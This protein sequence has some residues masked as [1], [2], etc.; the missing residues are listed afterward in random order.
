MAITA[1]RFP[2]RAR[3]TGIMALTAAVAIAGWIACLPSTPT[4]GAT[5]SPPCSL[6]ASTSGS[7]RNPGTASAPYL[8]V[9]HL[10]EKLN[11]GQAGC[12]AS[13]QT[14]SQGELDIRSGESHGAEGAPVTITSTNPS[15][16]ATI[17]GRIVTFPGADWLTFDHLTLKSSLLEEPG[18]VPVSPTIGSANTTWTY[19]DV[20]GGD[21]NICFGPHQAG[22]SWGPAE[23]TLIEHNRVHDC[24]HPVTLAELMAQASDTYC[25]GTVCRLSGWHA[26]GLYDEG[27]H[28]TVRNSYF[29]DNSGVGVL[30]RGG[31]YAVIE[32]NVIDHNGRG[33]EFGDDGPNHDVVAWNIVTNSTTPCGIEVGI[34]PHCSSYGLTSYCQG[35][36]SADT[37]RNN[38]LFGNEAGNIDRELSSAITLENNVKLNPRY[39]NAAAHDYTL[40][41]TSPVLGYGPDTAQPK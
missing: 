27:L 39:V 5:A 9:K 10:I 22:D 11:G 16:P 35:A 2:N 12:L 31:S 29:Y 33:V 32:H 37:F 40:Q 17:K 7:D 1:S 38:D 36:C 24:G 19:D 3:R 20:S 18:V 41:P 25:E 6:Y 15:E 26:H 23:Y 14:F 4:F 21:V 28:T 13:G 30:L 34:A 8:T